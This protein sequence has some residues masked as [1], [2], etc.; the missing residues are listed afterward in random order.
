M[1][2]AE[3]GHNDSSKGFH[4][5]Y[6]VGRNSG[7]PIGAHSSSPITISSVNPITE[8]GQPQSEE[9]NPRFRRHVWLVFDSCSGC[10]GGGG[11]DL[12]KS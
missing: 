8:T 6:L 7:E 5:G 3:C 11:L 1:D 12:T 9:W 2:Q 4:L 10:G